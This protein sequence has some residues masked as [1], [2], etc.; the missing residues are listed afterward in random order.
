MSAA[1]S[2]IDVVDGRRS[3]LEIDP[4]DGRAHD[5]RRMSTQDTVEIVRWARFVDPGPDASDAQRRA[6]VRVVLDLVDEPDALHDAWTTAL[7]MLARGEIT[8][9]VVALFA[10]A[11]GSSEVEASA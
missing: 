6:A 5:A 2:L 10:D 7:K 8:R 4:R 3:W 9:T 1:W 11:M